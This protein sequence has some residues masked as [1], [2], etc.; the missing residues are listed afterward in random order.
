M[1]IVKDSVEIESAL[2]GRVSRGDKRAFEDLYRR[3]S[4]NILGLA[5]YILNDRAAAEEVT[6]EVFVEIWRKAG[7]FDAGRGGA[8]SWVLRLTRSRAIDRLRSDRASQARDHRDFELNLANPGPAS[9]SDNAEAAAE[10]AEIRQAIDDIGEPN[11]TAVILSYYQGLSH[12]EI[13]ELNQIPLGTAKTRV[14][15]GM[16]RL[17]TLLSERGITQ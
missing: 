8:K 5:F 16:K 9:P 6:Q 12:N 1:I 13:A 3:L 17:A 2:L 11:R 4:G 14:R 7:D 15:N 10:R